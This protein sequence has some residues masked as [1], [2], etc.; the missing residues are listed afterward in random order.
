MAFAEY[1]FQIR[2]LKSLYNV[3][4]YTRFES[5]VSC[6]FLDLAKCGLRISVEPWPRVLLPL[7][8][9]KCC[10]QEDTQECLVCNNRLNGCV[11]Q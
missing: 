8:F 10:L 3:I 11:F 1:C 7:P 2:R 6:S 5:G 4:K 9:V